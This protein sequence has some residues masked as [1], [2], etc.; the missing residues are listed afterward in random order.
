MIPKNPLTEFRMKRGLS[1]A[2]LAKLLRVT[3]SSVAMWERGYHQPPPKYLEKLA[4]YGF[5]V[6]GFDKVWDEYIEAL[7]QATVDELRKDGFYEPI[8]E[9][10]TNHNDK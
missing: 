10:D 1:R 2:E 7:A 6:K 3:Y 4:P 5:D 9:G 8:D